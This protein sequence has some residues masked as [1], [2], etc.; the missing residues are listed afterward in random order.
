MQDLWF[1]GWNRNI[2]C[3]QDLLF[4]MSYQP[5]IDF[6]SVQL[7]ASFPRMTNTTVLHDFTSGMIVSSKEFLAFEMRLFTSFIMFNG[8]QSKIPINILGSAE[9][10][11]RW[12]FGIT[13][14][15]CVCFPYVYGNQ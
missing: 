11:S 13:V 4:L 9:Y 8:I 14:M 2:A 15:M 6:L 5:I 3:N 12:I 1:T 7:D 10:I